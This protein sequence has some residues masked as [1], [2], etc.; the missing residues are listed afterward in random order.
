MINSL[1]HTDG[2]RCRLLKLIVLFWFSLSIWRRPFNPPSFAEPVFSMF[3]RCVSLI[4]FPPTFCLFQ[5]GSVPFNHL[6]HGLSTFCA[7]GR[8]LTLPSFFSLCPPHRKMMVS[9]VQGSTASN[10]FILSW[11]Q[12]SRFELT[13]PCLLGCFVSLTA[14]PPRGDPVILGGFRSGNWTTSL[15]PLP[16][17]RF[18]PFLSSL[19]LLVASP[20]V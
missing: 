16:L 7:S 10:C 17:L 19:E 9:R 14:S 3:P 18:L 11:T 12:K 6:S 15:S 4:P 8:R 20:A 13:F 1:F 5:R 2:C